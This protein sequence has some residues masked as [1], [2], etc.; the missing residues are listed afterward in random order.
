MLAALAEWALAAIDALAACER[1]AGVDHRMHSN[2]RS[3]PCMLETCLQTLA[4]LCAAQRT[5]RTSNNSQPH[6]DGSVFH[7]VMPA[8]RLALAIARLP[9]PIRRAIITR[10]HRTRYKRGR[11]PVLTLAQKSWVKG[12]CSHTI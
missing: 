8:V 9:L 12:R 2:H 11:A 3:L 10:A 7:L 1:A 6:T 5:C 4:S